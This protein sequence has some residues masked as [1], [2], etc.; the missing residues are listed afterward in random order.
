MGAAALAAAA[1]SFAYQKY[2]TYQ[3]EQKMELLSE[4]QAGVSEEQVEDFVRLRDRLSS[5]NALLSNQIVLSRFFDTL[6]D[7]TLQNVRFNSMELAVAGDGSANLEV[8]GTARNFNTLAAQS[9]AFAGERGIRRAIFSSIALTDTRQVTFRLT[10]DIDAR[11]VTAGR[12]ATPLAS[13]PLTLPVQPVATTST[14]V[15][16]TSAPRPGTSTPPATVTA[17]AP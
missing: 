4:A 5:G 16:T 12:Q 2:L 9:N 17:P 3:L 10:A 8:E 13:D 7:L 15:A 14:S 1:G 11:L 6:E